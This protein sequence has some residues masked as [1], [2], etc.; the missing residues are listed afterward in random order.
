MM[1]HS[2]SL[3]TKSRE[4]II[5]DDSDNEDDLP[6]PPIQTSSQHQ[7][8]LFSTEP[9]LSA[10]E[11]Y[12]LFPSSPPAVQPADVTAETDGGSTSLE[13]FDMWDMWEFVKFSSPEDPETHPSPPALG[14]ISN[15]APSIEGSP[16][17]DKVL[18]DVSL[19]LEDP[20]DIDIDEAMTEL[21][22]EEKSVEPIAS[23]PLDTPIK[24]PIDTPRDIPITLMINKDL[25][26]LLD[27][28]EQEEGTNVYEEKEEDPN[29]YESFGAETMWAS[30]GKRPT[31]PPP[32]PKETDPVM[33]MSVKQWKW[34]IN[35]G[36][37]PWGPD[38]F[39]G[40]LQR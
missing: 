24:T 12:Q 34:C 20:Q 18:T 3:I 21:L 33:N 8:Q 10:E 11:A 13:M 40:M 6:P 19:S 4:K 29:V 32:P 25:A 2:Q 9:I 7:P 38:F 1:Q 39:K 14:D 15:V 31:T 22:G 37:G 16:G 28:E 27:E 23:I 35:N 17:V 5:G 26:F 30:E 36:R